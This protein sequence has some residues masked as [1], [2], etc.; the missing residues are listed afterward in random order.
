MRFRTVSIPFSHGKDR[1]RCLLAAVNVASVDESS[2]DH[3]LSHVEMEKFRSITSEKSRMRFA[4]GRIA[5]RIGLKALGNAIADNVSIIN[6]KNGRPRVEG[7]EYSVSISH[8]DN[9]AVSMIFKNG[10]AFGIDIEYSRPDKIRA[11]GRINRP[12]ELIPSDLASLTA[13]WSLKESLA[14]ALGY[15]FTVPFEEFEMCNFVET[16]DLFRC[17][18]SKHLD[19]RGLALVMGGNVLAM[20]HERECFFEDENAMRGDLRSLLAEV[21]P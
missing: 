1:D 13:A 10:F 3:W 6:G 4:A 2:C 20:V 7:S 8:S 16:G 18:F 15:G 11:L 12:S 5:S 9:S 19:F 17:D 14:K 21:N